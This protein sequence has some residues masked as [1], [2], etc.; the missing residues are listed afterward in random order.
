MSEPLH[1]LVPEAEAG[2]RVDRHVARRLE[3]PRNQVQRWIA[4]DRVTINRRPV[5]A[6]AILGAA[7]TVACRPPAES[8]RAGLEPEVGPP[9]E[10]LFE[11]AELVVLNKPAGMA[12]HPGAGRRSSTL[13]HYLLHSYP[14]MSAVGGPGRPGIVHRLDIDTTGVLVVARSERAYLRLSEAFASRT[15]RKSY[16]AIVYG[17]PQSSDGEIELPIGR[18]PRDRKRMAIRR[19]GRPA[20]TRYRRLRS[21]RGLSWLQLELETGRTHQL[22]VHLKAIGHPLVGD[23]VY[24]EARWRG[25]ERSLERPLLRFPRPALHAWRLAF[26]HPT[27]SRSLEV[28]APVPEDIRQLWLET[29]G[30]APPAME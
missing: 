30:E 2:E 14:E 13:A 22:R 29:T 26:T 16:Q 7:D 12:V 24:G 15:I 1:W 19:N 27:T 4:E 18:H 23:P 3:V 11:D 21:V 8:D 9:L 28:E 10:V 5:K 6:S 20:R 25:L 17:T